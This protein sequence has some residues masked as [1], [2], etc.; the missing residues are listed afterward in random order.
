MGTEITTPSLDTSGD[1]HII[2]ISTVVHYFLLLLGLV[3]EWFAI[4]GI[5]KSAVPDL[6]GLIQFFTYSSIIMMLV[7]QF[8]IIRNFHILDHIDPNHYPIG[9]WVAK[10]KIEDII[11]FL[12]FI[13]FAALTGEIIYLLIVGSKSIP[14]LHDL[15]ADK[16]GL[17]DLTWITPMYLISALSMSVVM[18]IWDWVGLWHD[19]NQVP[20]FG[21]RRFEFSD[22]I[23]YHPFT[24]PYYTFIVTDFIALYFWGLIN[25][26][27]F[28][29]PNKNV[30][31][32]MLALL[33]LAYAFGITIRIWAEW[34]VNIPKVVLFIKNYREN[35]FWWRERSC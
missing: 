12:L 14:F 4:T 22:K 16:N 11:R 15:M 20:K 18:L 9:N 8:L 31:M 29:K 1:S 30:V 26:L 10:C 6:S 33:F 35:T 32:F 27:V 34:K 13:L 7:H 28:F 23:I 17:Y 3:A 25:Y 2:N 24:S 19:W 21:L 5:I